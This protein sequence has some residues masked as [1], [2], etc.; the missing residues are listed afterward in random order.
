MKKRFAPGFLLAFC[1]FFT[2]LHAQFN[3]T[4]PGGKLLGIGRHADTLFFWGENHVWRSTDWGETMQKQVRLQTL[5]FEYSF[6]GAQGCCAGSE[7]PKQDVNRFSYVKY[8][9]GSSG[10]PNRWDIDIFFPQHGKL[11]NLPI[12]GSIPPVLSEK[13][14]FYY[15]F[16]GPVLRFF[17]WDDTQAQVKT[18]DH[19]SLASNTYR[20]NNGDNFVGFRDARV[21]VLSAANNGIAEIDFTGNFALK[22]ADFHNLNPTETAIVGSDSL[23]YICNISEHTLT[24]RVHPIFPYSQ[25][26]KW[27]DEFAYKN[28]DGLTL[29]NVSMD[30]TWVVQNLPPGFENMDFHFLGRDYLAFFDK[31][32]ESLYFSRDLGQNWQYKERIGMFARSFSNAFNIGDTIYAHR[33]ELLY[34]TPCDQTDGPM[35]FVHRMPSLSAYPDARMSNFR[36]LLVHDN[37][38]SSDLGLSW[39]FTPGVPFWDHDYGKMYAYR[40]D[41]DQIAKLY[42]SEDFGQTWD[43]IQL[44]PDAVSLKP[45]IKGFA[46]QNDTMIFCGHQSFDGGQTW[47][48]FP[49]NL[50]YA[51]AFL[52]ILNVHDGR[53]VFVGKPG[54]DA[55]GIHKIEFGKTFAGPFTQVGVYQMYAKREKH[56]GWSE[57]TTIY[58]TYTTFKYLNLGDAKPLINVVVS[59]SNYSTTRMQPYGLEDNYVHIDTTL[60]RLGEV[61]FSVESCKKSV[62]WQG[63]S[64]PVGDHIVSGDLCDADTILHVVAKNFG[65]KTL[66]QQHLCEGDSV[67]Y[68]GLWI[69]GNA[70]VLDTISTPPG[71][72]DTVVTQSFVWVPRKVTTVSEH[73]L[74]HKIAFGGGIIEN[75]TTVLIASNMPFGCPQEVW[76]AYQF[77]DA[78]FATYNPVI[79]FCEGGAFN[80]QGQVYDKDTTLSTIVLKWTGA[81][82]GC[83]NQIQVI[84]EQDWTNDTLPT[85]LVFCYDQLIQFEGVIYPDSA[86]V[87]T[88]SILSNCKKLFKQLLRL[89]VELETKD[90]VSFIPVVVNGIA[91][92]KD[93]TLLVKTYYLN[94]CTRKITTW[95]IDI[96]S[97]GSDE[98]AAGQMVLVMPN[99]ADRRIVVKTSVPSVDKVF[100]AYDAQGRLC[101]ERNWDTKDLELD[102]SALPAGVYRWLCLYADKR[103]QGQF[104]IHR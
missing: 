60:Y 27:K 29:Y 47:S 41:T 16:G 97:L 77:I 83:N 28:S 87:Q 48:V 51:Q 67:F 21:L 96:Q 68:N 66:P 32:T 2:P 35:T 22:D 92:Y 18:F 79:R 93:T 86:F 7:G 65:Q 99:P 4:I 75:D 17:Y 94:G 34:K 78:V 98:A 103:A 69:R 49:E 100:R 63:Q 71:I 33:G 101:I 85:P 31:K 8:I 70:S 30:S 36:H 40:D 44:P 10:G 55:I 38:Y 58:G 81:F 3:L 15:V 1:L 57:T 46:A 13:A 56:A 76:R 53:F 37:R 50:S 39:K 19:V 23:F 72:C 61:A 24:Q 104:V 91:Y 45:F 11:Q 89:P 59:H 43:T 62:D 5:G 64:Y 95:N 42:R 73:C 25:I 14:G 74:G 102:V 12:M 80:Y 54:I 52:Q 90:T 26:W 20:R 82:T 84:D 9:K 6:S 88:G